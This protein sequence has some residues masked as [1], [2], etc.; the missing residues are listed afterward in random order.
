MRSVKPMARL[1]AASSVLALTSV[2]AGIVSASGAAMQIAAPGSAVANSSL[3]SFTNAFVFGE[4]Q[5]VTLAQAAPVDATTTGLF[6]ALSDLTPG[7]VAIGTVVSSYYLHADPVGA[8][9]TLYTYIGSITFDSDILGVAAQNADLLATN[10]L[11]AAGT[12]YPSAANVNGLDFS[13]GTDSFT[14]SGDRRTLSFKLV[15]YAGSDA[16][17]VITEENAVPEPGALGLAFAAAGALA[18]TRRR[19]VAQA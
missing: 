9:S 12:T 10:F 5:N 8:S 17:R 7:S 16:L 11:G 6:D 18:L 14:I 13:E 1:L 15:A 19:Q 2:Q 3:E 4:R